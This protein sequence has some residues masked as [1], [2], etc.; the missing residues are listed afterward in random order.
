MFGFLLFLFLGDSV[1]HRGV[2]FTSVNPVHLETLSDVLSGCL[3]VETAMTII[4]HTV[5]TGCGQLV[6]GISM[7]AR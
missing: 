6:D 2:F 3:L 5:Q 4:T 7:E 1:A